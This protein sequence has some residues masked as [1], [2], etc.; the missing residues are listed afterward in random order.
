MNERARADRAAC[1]SIRAGAARAACRRGSSSSTRTSTSAPT[2]TAS[3]RRSTS[4][5]G[6]CARYGRRASVRVL[7]GRA[8]PR[9]GVPRGERPHARGGRGER[10]PADPVRAPR[11][12]R[13]S[14]SRR[15]RAASTSARAASSSIRARSAS[16]LN[17]ERL[18]PVFALAAERRVPILIHG[19]RGLPPIA[20]ELA[21]LMDAHPGRAAHH[22]PRRDRRPRRALGALRGTAERLLRHVRLEPGRPARR[23]PPLLARAGALRLRLPVRPAADVAPPRAR[24]TARAAGLDDEQLRNMLGGTRE[25]HRRGRADRPS[26]PRRAA[27]RSRA[28]DRVR[29]DPPATSPWRRRSSGR[30]QPDTIG[31]LGLALNACRER[32][33][34]AEARERIARAARRGA[35][36]LAHAARGGG[37]GRARADRRARPSGS[38]TSPTSRR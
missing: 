29:A 1:S 17:D 4:S 9:P 36:A 30:G 33:G 25:P 31:V 24:R 10:G 8:R 20:D 11:P 38:S 34:Y 19:G 35:R 3:S 15:R 37:R 27:P 14:R 16:C 28:A 7:H 13:T 32:D 18:A 12:R 2:S 26:P 22:R 5:S 21:R 23:V 6:S